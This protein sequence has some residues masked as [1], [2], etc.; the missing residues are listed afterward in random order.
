MIGVTEAKGLEPVASF[1]GAERIAYSPRDGAVD[2]RFASQR[3][4]KAAE[5][6]GLTL[7][8][9]CS[10]NGVTT[11]ANGQSVIQT[12]CGDINVDKYVIATGADPEATRVTGRHRYST[13]LN[14]GVIVVT[15]PLPMMLNTISWR[16]VFIFTNAW[17]VELY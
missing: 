6:F 4:V 9:N 17:T 2:A 16:P 15:E 11:A 14:A 10:V 5:K 8:E 13:A 7:L 3:M 1:G 12:T